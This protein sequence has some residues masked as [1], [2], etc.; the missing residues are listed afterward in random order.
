MKFAETLKQ[1]A[2]NV[3]A[4]YT[5]EDALRPVRSEALARL[6]E[7]HFPHR[8]VEAWK[9]TSVRALE[10]GHLE[11]V[12]K[13]FAA[14]KLPE[15]QFQHRLVFINGIYSEENSTSLPE[16]VALELIDGHTAL[17][18]AEAE[19][20]TPF[21][22]LNS[23]TL[24]HGAV[25]KVADNTQVQAPVEVLFLSEAEAP[26]HCHARLQVELGEN[27]QLA[28]LEHYSGQGPVLTNAVTTLKGDT[29]S[30]L[31]HYRVQRE[32]TDSLHIGTLVVLPGERSDFQSYQ[33]MHGTT[34]R[35]NDVRVVI[36]HENTN[37]SQKGVFVG[38]EKHHAD[39]Q[40][41]VE[42]RVPNSTSNMVYK[43]MAAGQCTL[44]FNG[45]IHI[46]PG[47]SQTVADLTNN[48]LQLNRG[49]TVNSKPEL[50]IYND[51]V[52][53]S[54]GTTFGQLDEDAIFYLRSRGI[55]AQEAENILSLAFIDEVLNAMPH[56]TLA[57]WARP[58]LVD[59]LAKAK[60][61]ES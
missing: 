40:V 58:W 14:A 31:V 61:E 25:L 47:A 5:Q 37:F 19:L 34:L 22:L 51:D 17:N 23:A 2:L 36:E 3:A 56:E 53:C 21:A 45:S 39:N 4:N 50:I 15:A 38:A 54:H 59:V 18:G 1:Q 49:A 16:G 6:K 48:N 30:Q 26:S 44:T 55:D 20:T 35:R 52:Q 11:Q 9:Y 57:Q 46:H 42:H 32:A 27:S 8:R 24:D 43:G 29:N 13:P 12:A 7:A 41:S 60:A 33:L 28:L 10:A